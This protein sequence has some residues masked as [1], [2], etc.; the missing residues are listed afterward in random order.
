MPDLKLTGITKRFDKSVAVDDLSLSIEHGEFVCLL[1]PSGCGKTTTL[2]MIAGF[3]TANSGTIELDGMDITR[4][5]PQKRDIG[6]VF[7][8]YALFPHK[9]AAENVGFGLKMR[10]LP[11]ADIDSQVKKALELV[12]LGHV[13]D[14]YPRQMSGGQQQRVA[15][16]RALAIRPRLLLMDEPLSNLDAKLRDEMR[17]EIR[18]IQK[19]VGITAIFVTHDQAEAL[20]LADRIAVMSEGRLMQIADPTSIYESPAN[21]TV[22]QFIGQVN[23]LQGSV[24]NIDGPVVHVAIAGGRYIS[25]FDRQ[26]PAGTPV[27][28]MVK[29]ER[30]FLSRQQPAAGENIFPCQ[31]EGRTYLGASIVYRCNLGDQAMTAAVP[32]HPAFEQ[33]QP[34]DAAFLHWASADCRLFRQ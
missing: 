10:K 7:Q 32:N 20:A 19:E 16:A 31:V 18:R 9:T 15:L 30:V 14:R 26:I 12:R 25:G 2:R 28:A 33:F 34:G 11:R 5:P 4:L 29:H 24:A 22:D 23:A 17:E 13:A 21:A 8:S 1:G 6:L 27:L 3:E